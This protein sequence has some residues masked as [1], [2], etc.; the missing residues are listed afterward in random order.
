MEGRMIE[1]FGGPLDGEAAVCWC[2]DRAE[3]RFQ[4]SMIRSIGPIT[5]WRA[6][7]ATNDASNSMARYRL[8]RW[9]GGN[10]RAK[11]SLDAMNPKK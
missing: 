11:F 7:R 10:W 5:T 9:V 3:E 6:W 4:V 2:P 8:I 1:F